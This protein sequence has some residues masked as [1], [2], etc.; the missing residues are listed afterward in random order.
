M[1][2]MPG[3]RGSGRQRNGH[4]PSPP[5]VILSGTTVVLHNLAKQP[6]HNGKTGRVLSFDAS[7]GR[8]DVQLVEGSA[9]LALRAQNLTQ[10]CNLEVAGLESKPELNGSTGDIFNYDDDTGRY[11]VLM[12]NPPVALGLHRKNCVFKEGTRVV[13]AELSAEKF[14]GQMAHIV[15]VD[16]PAGRYTVRCQNGSEIKVKY[17]NVCC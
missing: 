8:Y 12:Q 3:V 4:R 14:N 5:Y 1:G 11:M 15:S 13:L 2:G 6:E 17:A 9:V 10:Q 7:K 16:R